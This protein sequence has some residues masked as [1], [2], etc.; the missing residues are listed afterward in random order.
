MGWSI[1][2]NSVNR[3]LARLRN[4]ITK[5]LKD[6]NHSGS[7]D[8][9]LYTGSELSKTVGQF[10]LVDRHEGPPTFGEHRPYRQDHV[11]LSAHREQ[12]QW[13]RVVGRSDT[14]SIARPHRHLSAACMSLS[15]GI[16]ET[17]ADI[18]SIARFARHKSQYK[19]STLEARGDLFM[20]PRN[21]TELSVSRVETLSIG[22]IKELGHR[23]IEQV[24]SHALKGWLIMEAKL[25]HSIRKFVVVADEPDDQHFHHAH[26]TGFPLDKSEL[27]EAADDLAERAGIV[28][29]VSE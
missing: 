13:H 10:L 22:A 29:V 8:E 23:I 18:E 20:P 21:S 5:L 11:C 4:R 16:P 6:L 15:S 27:M 2:H 12:G 9:D 24:P 26:I 28:T 3:N 7:A 25:I 1:E 19:P 17:I 14:G